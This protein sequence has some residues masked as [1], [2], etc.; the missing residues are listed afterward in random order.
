MRDVNHLASFFPRLSA[1]NVLYC[2]RKDDSKRVLPRTAVHEDV[3][4]CMPS[5]IAPS[6]ERPPPTETAHRTKVAIACQR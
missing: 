1:P 5:I 4:M 2:T 3:P 6:D